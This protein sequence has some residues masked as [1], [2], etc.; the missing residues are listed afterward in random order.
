VRPPASGRARCAVAKCRSCKKEV[1]FAETSNGKTAPF[2]VNKDGGFVI[3]NGKARF[4]GKER[5]QLE[6]GAAPVTHYSNHFSTCP[7]AAKWRG[8][9]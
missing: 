3:E 5:A 2:E 4:V 6:L 9:K 8:K 7:D 1:V